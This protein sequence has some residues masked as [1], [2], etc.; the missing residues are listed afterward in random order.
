MSTNLKSASNF[1]EVIF[2]NN[3]KLNKFILLHASAKHLEAIAEIFYNI[4]RLPLSPTIRSNFIKNIRILKKFI[5]HRSHRGDIARK[6]SKLFTDLLISIK[7][8]LRSIW[9]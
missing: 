4:F 9:K 5:H 1:L 7:S 3:Q 2:E 8:Y 6:N